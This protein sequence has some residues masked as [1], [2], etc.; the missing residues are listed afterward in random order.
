MDDASRLLMADACYAPPTVL[1]RQPFAIDLY[2]ESVGGKTP[3]QLSAETGIPLERVEI[4][5]VA[6][7]KLMQERIGEI[8]VI[9][10]GGLPTLLGIS[11]ATAVGTRAAIATWIMDL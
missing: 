10:I 6:A 3:E 7:T 8:E 4:R 5:V 9:H 11:D 1:T 2:E